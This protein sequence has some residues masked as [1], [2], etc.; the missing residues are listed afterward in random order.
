MTDSESMAGAALHGLK[1]LELAQLIAAPMAG[2]FLADLGADVVHVE[3][4]IDGDAQRVVGVAKDGV[5]LWWK[6][7]ARNKRSVVL[8]LRTPGG[9]RMARRLIEWADVLITNFR[10]ETLSSW[11][12]DW[13]DAHALNAKLVMLHI[14]GFGLDSSWR[15]RPGF[16]KVAEAMS[17]VVHV[18]G[19]PDGPPVHTGFSHG[20]AVSG[21]FGAYAV[22][23]A[24]YRRERDPA[25][26][27]ELIDLALFEG[28]YR[29]C[30]WQIIM[31]DQLGVAPARAGNRPANV[32]AAVVNT[33]RSKDDEWVT[34][35]SGTPRSVLK[36]AALLGEDPALYDTPEKQWAQ[37]K[38]LDNRLREYIASRPT[39]TVLAE[40]AA[41]E[42]VASRIFSAEDIVNDEIFRERG[43][44]IR[45]TDPELGPVRMQAALPKLLHHG[46]AVWRTGPALGEDNDLVF[47]EYLGMSDDEIAAVAGPEATKR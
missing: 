3:P 18:T 2:S 5:H 38:Y 34:V 36:V 24:L 45:V 12:L 28:L 26:D 6:V 23:A 20:D 41:A 17:G 44:V 37:Q 46:G 35:T 25:F 30:E 21:L 8:D 19:F 32:P 40:M 43:D 47:R 10:P 42:V 1:V 16:G 29:L 4:P 27:G 39:D 9:Q 31:Y 22:M 13:Q 33:Y 7:T 14:T 15:N 11:G